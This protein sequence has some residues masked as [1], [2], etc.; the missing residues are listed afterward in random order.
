MNMLNIMNIRKSLLV[1]AAV[2]ASV[3][4]YSQSAQDRWTIGSK[5]ELVWNI[6][7]R[8]PHS[9]FIEMSGQMVSTIVRYNVAADSSFHVDLSMVWPMLRTIP[10]N[11]HASLNRHFDEDFA[12]EIFSGKRPL[13]HFRTKAVKLDG[14]LETTETALASGGSLELHRTFFPSVD[15]PAFCTKYVL[16]NISDKEIKLEIPSSSI[17][18]DTPAQDGVYGSYR[19]TNRV[20]SSRQNITLKPSEEYSFYSLVTGTKEGEDFSAIDV[21]KELAA[22]KALVEEWRGELVLD[23]PDPVLNTMFSFAKIRGA[24]SIFKTKGGFMHSPGGEAYYA[25][26]W[27]N[28][29]AEYIGPFFPYLGYSIG[30]E[31]SFNAYRHFA[32]YMNVGYDP[33]PS[34]IIAEGVDI[35]NGAGDRGDAAMLAYGASRFALALGD[36]M[37]AEELWVFIEWCL[38]YCHRHLSPEGVVLSDSDELEGRFPSGKA[39]LCTSTLYY[40]ALNSAA[41]LGK[42]L[43]KTYDIYVLRAKMLARNIEKYFGANVEG[44]D[45]Y[46]YYDGNDKLRSWICIPLT[47]GIFDRREGTL[48]ALFDK[49]WTGNGLL[50]QSGTTTY[51]DRSTLYAL[52]GAFFAGDTERALEHLDSYSRT[53]LLGE[54]VPYAIE[55]WP[56]GNQRQLSAESGLYCRIFTE[57]LFGMRPTGLRS[58][59]FTP[60]LP[61]GWDKMSLRDIHAFAGRFDI[62]VE[63]DGDAIHVKVNTFGKSLVN[64]K[65]KPGDKLSVSLE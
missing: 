18:Y 14:T 19:L 53:R 26:I 8:V 42:A 28:D 30:N 54:H 13:S 3:S 37:K 51:W 34:S 29:Q 49:L 23:T 36:R 62:E 31:A 7:G 21:E 63:R 41:Y 60:R 9:D 33:I 35:W 43:G 1:V 58:F 12:G 16:K 65:I 56:E 48:N 24:E 52:R 55:A 47:V 15:K 46:R 59:E 40:D 10:N 50:S 17:P 6:D 39:N 20:I 27:A 57:G 45:T 44:Y 61:S 11:T 32:R 5:G 2:L 4:A 64:K 22:R 38:E 25:A